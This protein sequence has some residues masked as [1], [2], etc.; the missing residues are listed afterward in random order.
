MLYKERVLRLVLFL[1]LAMIS[2]AILA[3]CTAEMQEGCIS[4]RCG[5]ESAVVSGATTGSAGSAGGGAPNECSGTPETGAYP[6]DVYQVLKTSCFLCHSDPPLT[7][8]SS[9]LTF[10]QT[11]LTDP[12]SGRLVADAM[13]DHIAAGT[14]PIGAPLTPEAKQTLLDWLDG[15]GVPEP[16]GQGCE[17]LEPGAC[18]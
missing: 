13:R 3:A 9:L 14:M 15:C 11:R 2:A 6:C 17:C 4:G 12:E 1:P 18:P 10:E 5:P 16:E 7:G 8:A